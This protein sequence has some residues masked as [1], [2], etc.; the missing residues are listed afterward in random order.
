MQDA[1]KIKNDILNYIDN[2][3]SDINKHVMKC[4]ST[5]MLVYFIAFLLNAFDIFI[6]DKQIMKAGFIPSIIIYIVVLVVTKCLSLSDKRMKYFILFCIICVF[7]L[8]GVTITYH[9]VVIALLPILY[10]TLYSSKKV[11]WYVYGLTVI[12]T[13]IVV[14]GGYFYG[15]CDANMV[16]LTSTKLE[17]YVVDGVFTLTTINSNPLI[18]LL[19]FY[20]IPR[21]LIQVAFIVIC[22]NIFTLI[23][24][25][26]QKAAYLAQMENLKIQKAEMEKEKAE[27]ASKA[28]SSFLSSMS[29][30]IRTPMNAIVG[31]TEV[32]L[33]GTHSEE[34]REYLNN[35]KVSGESLLTI[36]NDILDFS[37]IESG[38]MDIVENTYKPISM[39]NDLK[40]IFENRVIDKPIELIYHVD[41]NIPEMLCGDEHRLRQV[42][43]NLVN[44]AIKFTDKGYVKLSVESRK[45]NA[46]KVELIFKVEDTGIGIKEEELPKLFGS[47]EQLDVKKNYAKEGT[48]LGLAISKQLVK[49]MDGKI[50]VESRYGQGS[51]FYFSVPQTIATK[52]INNGENSKGYDNRIE[53]SKMNFTLSKAHILLVDDNEMNIK[54]TKALLAPFKMCIDTASN[55]KEAVDMVRNN[56]YDLV[57]MDHMMPVMDGVE[58]TKVIRNLEGEYYVTL[59]IIALTANV[60]QD[61]RA[62]FAKEKMNDF[63]AKPIQIEEITDC[64]LKWLP[65][66]LIEINSEAEMPENL[67]ASKDDAEELPIIEGIDSNEGVKNC[68]SKEVFFE[69]VKD[70]YKL[71]DSKS[72]KI[73]ECLKEDRIREF[74]IEVHALKST[75]RMVGAMQLSALAYELE[76]LGNQNAKE[77]I[78]SKTPELLRLYRQYK[79]LLK[80]YGKT[81]S[82]ETMK[83]SPIQIKETL[84]RIHDAVENF[85][86]DEADKA[87]EELVT[88]EV[89]EDMKKMVEQLGVY[90]AD[91]AM[92]EVIR[93]TQEMCDKLSD[94][95]E[96]I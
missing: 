55:G 88:Y 71:I 47:F 80:E 9:V 90:V 78:E 85:D 74:T 65:K 35:I 16:L 60:M 10:A 8:I 32:L 18:T 52:E 89:S 33:R 73:E 2:R 29:H 45:I 54:V 63:V 28:K 27:A 25:S 53:A 84:M 66:E 58:A 23:E 30:E 77:E 87:M 93:I 37:K 19:V 83:V 11:M 51:T 48:G 92:E 96:E 67:H 13:I 6:I 1:E 42:I 95:S 4:F 79:E 70:F 26:H 41:D 34:T 21:C 69:L 15:L 17:N 39:L 76:Q 44:N 7:T 46:E 43:I 22:N 75:A 56:K 50:G 24:E 3:E 62:L 68:G 5:A 12:S 31:M 81:E 14:Y 40:M 91:V 82:E 20:V 38:K 59:P 36:I 72:L 64:L 61:A 86:L 57:F 94:E 49:L